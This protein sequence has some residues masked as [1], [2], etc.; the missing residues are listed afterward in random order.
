MMFWLKKKKSSK[1]CSKNFIEVQNI[2]HAWLDVIFCRVIF[3]LLFFSFFFFAILRK[4]FFWWLPKFSFTFIVFASVA[5]VNF[6][7]GN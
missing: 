6:D 5:S 7:A 3:L 2:L 4:T 1:K